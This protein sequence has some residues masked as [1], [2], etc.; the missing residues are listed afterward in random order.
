VLVLLMLA[1]LVGPVVNA[2]P[3]GTARQLLPTVLGALFI[4]TQQGVLGCAIVGGVSVFVY[5]LVLTRCPPHC[6]TLFVLGVLYFVHAHRSATDYMGWKIGVETILMVFTGKYISFAYNVSDGRKHAA[7]EPLSSKTHEHESRS[8]LAL[9]C[10]P[11]PFEY[12][13]FVLAYW[14][15][16][17]G[18]PFGMAEFLQW[19]RREGPFASLHKVSILRSM[20]PVLL[21]TL[22]AAAGLGLHIAVFP[23]SDWTPNHLVAMP[24]PKRLIFLCLGATFSRFRYYFAWTLA[25]LGGNSCGFGLLD[26]EASPPRFGRSNNCNTSPSS[27]RPPPGPP[28]ATGTSTRLSG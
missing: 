15:V 16:V 22:G 8:K 18:P 10:I 2:L 19:Q 13:A 17:A 24:L 12:T 21:K 3:A 6:V 28:L 9:N 1:I 20:P 11:T 26:A 5:V 7:G 4:F 27:S 23:T 25:E 14:D